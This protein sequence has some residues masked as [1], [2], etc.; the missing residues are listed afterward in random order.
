MRLALC[1]L[2]ACWTSS[3]PQESPEPARACN[4]TCVEQQ[5]PPL[6]AVIAEVTAQENYNRAAE[7][8]GAGRLA[9]GIQYVRV[10]HEQ[11]PYSK[12]RQ[13]GGDLTATTYATELETARTSCRATCDDCGCSDGICEASCRKRFTR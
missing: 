8:F 13:L 4:R 2:C 5:L 12:Y 6:R 10:L 7:H 9:I 3:A 1:L 11:F